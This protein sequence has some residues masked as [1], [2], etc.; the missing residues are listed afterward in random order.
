MLDGSG[1]DYAG[2][3]LPDVGRQGSAG[4]N[5][6]CDEMTVRAGILLK[7]TGPDC[8]LTFRTKI[9]T[10]DQMNSNAHKVAFQFVC[11]GCDLQF[12]DQSNLRLFS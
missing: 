8:I 11:L 3:R 12:K 6:R 2:V 10:L 7:D 9:V 4:R 5:R 1:A